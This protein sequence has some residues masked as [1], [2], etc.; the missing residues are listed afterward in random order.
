MIE[1]LAY[2][3]LG[4]TLL[5]GLIAL[6]NL[7][8]LERLPNSNE[9]KLPEK[10]Y[11]SVLIPARN[12]A[13]NIGHLLSDIEKMGSESICEVIVCD[14]QSEDSTAEV[15]AHYCARDT[16]FRLISSSTLPDGWLGK[17]HACHTLAMEAKGD[18]LLFLDADVRIEV[19]FVESAIAY[20]QR[21]QV[22][23]LTLFPTQDMKTWAEKVS[24]PN[25]HII[26]LTLLFLPMVR[27]SKRVSLSAANGQCMVFRRNS[28]WKLRPHATYRHS[29]AEDIE[30]ARYF[31]R[32]QYRVACL[33]GTKSIH[34]KMYSDW[35][36]A[37]EGFAKNVTYF[38]GHSNSYFVALLYW[39]ITTL[40]IL[41]IICTRSSFLLVGYISIIVL[42]RLFV[43]LTAQQS[44]FFNILLMLPQ[45]LMLGAFI[46]KS[47]Y[48]KR[49][50]QFLW[51]GRAI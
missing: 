39:V 9:I 29:R 35:R 28:Y 21:R 48:N 41:P 20:V 45:Q 46:F 13:D 11:V 25:M 12:E 44:P 31:K 36:G 23:L 26:L 22:D 7:L 40:G 43:S 27:L 24:V 19:G 37:L 49:R 50:R 33:T 8:F 10:Y 18:F 6:L 42:T 2:I 14:D 38:F 15:V 1:Y 51:K 16:R 47:W 3:V 34:C 17:N 32:S 4:F 5:R 30:I